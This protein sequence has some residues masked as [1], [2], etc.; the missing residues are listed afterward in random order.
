ML[1]S[2]KLSISTKWSEAGSITVQNADLGVTGRDVATVDALASTNT[3]KLI[4][5]SPGPHAMLLRFRS[6]GDEDV[7]DIL[8]LYAARGNDFYSRVAQLTTVVGTGDTDV[9]TIHFVD[10]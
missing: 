10:F 6:D 4:P 2:N 8:Q 1:G 9:A 5:P 7:D 3:I